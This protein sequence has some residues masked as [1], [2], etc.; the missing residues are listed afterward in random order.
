VPV[1]LQLLFLLCCCSFRS[2]AGIG[3]VMEY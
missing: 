2:S 3:A 1:L